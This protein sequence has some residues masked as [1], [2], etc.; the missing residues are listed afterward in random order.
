[1][2]D[3]LALQGLGELADLGDQLAPAD[4]R[5]VGERLVPTATGWSTRR[6]DTQSCPRIPCL[7]RLRRCDRPPREL[8]SSRCSTRVCTARPSC[9]SSSPWRSRRSR[10][11]RARFRCS[12][13][14]APDA[15]Q[16]ARAFAELQSLAGDVSRS[17]A[18]A[19]KAT[20]AWRSTIAA[21]AARA[22]RRR[23][24]GLLGARP[25]QRRADDR[26]QAPAHHRHRR[27]PGLDQRDA[28]RDR[29]APR[30]GGAR[31]RGRAVGHRGAARA[32]ARVRRARDQAHDRAR[33]DERRQRRRGRRRRAVARARRRTRAR[34][35]RRRDRASATSRA[36]PR[37]GRWCVP[38]SDGYGLGAPAA[39][40]HGRRR[41]AA[42]VGLGPGRAERARPA[43][44]PRAAARPSAN[45]ACS[46]PKA[47][48]RCWCRR[49]GE[50]GPSPGGAGERGT[51]AKASAAAV[52]QRGRRARRGTRRGARRCRPG[53]CCSASSCRGGPCSSLVGA[54]LL[55]AAAR[56][57]RRA[58]AAAPPAPAGRVA[59]RCGR[60][61]ARSR[62]CCVRCSPSCSAAS[63]SPRPP[64]AVLVLPR[65]VPLDATAA[66]LL[67]GRGRS[68][69][70]SRGCG[71]A[72]LLR[73]RG[74]AVRPGSR[75][76]GAVDAARAAAPSASSSGSPI[77]TR[78]CCSCP[79]CTCGCCSPRPSCAPR[80][81]DRRRSSQAASCR[82]GCSLAFYAHQLGFG[83]GRAR[84]GVLPAARGR[85]RGHRR[86]RCCGASRSAARRPP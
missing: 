6:H 49:R 72:A 15:F 50:R 47:C 53:S 59:G 1:M 44:A 82:S 51:A 71:W 11:G 76:G 14:L 68:R 74:W 78:L 36:P 4:V 5:V 81:S 8:R 61:C 23:R 31:Q 33:L 84:L 2:H 54:L 64:R 43:R 80:G 16:G 85:R 37:A 65:A 52:L 70:C 73:R 10:W 35:A 25:A 75:R 77:R 38:F 30:R 20:N 46:T 21:H 24:R 40:A 13:T 57:R 39:A 3:A 83:P 62:S 29:R 56:A 79:R 63:A 34:R 41:G 45:R 26:R 86:R 60:S 22:R 18:R 69:S 58:R 48:P 55:R 66:A 67:G 19:A 32:R 9:L 27:T 17:G 12:S 28:D 42:R 7:S